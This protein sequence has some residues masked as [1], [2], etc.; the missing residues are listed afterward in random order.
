MIAAALAV[1]ISS[2]GAVLAASGAASTCIPAVPPPG[3]G[4]VDPFAPPAP[5]ATE[6]NAD[7]KALYRQGKWEE[8]RAQYRAALAADP[9]FLAPK[10]N[11]AC[12]FVRQERFA[13]ATAE[14]RA[15]IAEGYIPWTREILEAADMGALKVRPEMGGLRQAMADAAG[16]WGEGLADS[17]VFVGRQRAPLR[18]PDGPG[19]FILNPH[20]EVYAYVPAT[21]LYRQ[22]T[23]ED[24][25]VLAQARTPDGRRIVY[26]TAEKLVRGAAP[27]RH[28]LRGVALGEITLATMAAAPPVRVDGDVRRIEILAGPRGP[29]FRIEREGQPGEGQFV[30]GEGGVLLPLGGPRLKKPLAVLTA[31]EGAL[32]APPVAAGGRCPVVARE[33]KAVDGTR[34]IEL[35]VGGRPARRLG[36]RFGAGL[37]GLPIP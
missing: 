25:R 15:L 34:R 19:V 2:L 10:L 28:M 11:I 6:L 14:A 5:K 1:S 30:R 4:A 13:E 20:Q 9:T 24:G 27:G 36:E 12:S 23:A 29:T 37:G 32:A 18:I 22:L 33:A 17:V 8:A 3:L 31:A 16:R 26:V 35:L 21:G 7:G